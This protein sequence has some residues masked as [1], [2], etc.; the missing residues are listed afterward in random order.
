MKLTSIVFCL[1]SVYVCS[2]QTDKYAEFQQLHPEYVFMSHTNYNSVSDEIKLILGDKVFLFNESIE[3]IEL[4]NLIE[5]SQ[6]E[7]HS[8]I[9]SMGV[10]ENFVKIW[11]A[12]N[13]TIKIVP[14]SQ[15]S[16]VTVE[17]QQEY[18][19]HNCLILSGE[20]LTYDDVINYINQH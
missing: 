20:T 13:P 6:A 11:L 15:F 10:P 18:I 1:F 2:A 9:N 16:E 12:E 5:K 19:D 17:M 3:E 4:P 14:N 8:L 7:D